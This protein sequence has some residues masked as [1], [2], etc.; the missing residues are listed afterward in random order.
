MRRLIRK[1]IVPIQTLTARNFD[2]L[3]RSL[4]KPSALEGRIEAQVKRLVRDVAE[5]GDQA[6]I[7]LTRRFDGVSL[8]PSELRVKQ[9]EVRAAYERVSRE[10]LM[11]LELAKRNVE[12]AERRW[13]AHMRRADHERDGVKI[14]SHFKPLE[15]V[16][17]Y[18]PGGKA[19]YPSSVLMNAL[20][21]KLA[22]V[23]RIVLCTPPSGGSRDVNSL[24][25]VAAALCGITEIYRVGGAQAIAAL[26]YGTDTIKP[27]EKIVGPGNQYV[28]V[29]KHLVSRHVA[30]DSPAGPSELLVIADQSVDPRLILNDLVSQAEHGEDSV[31]GLLTTSK[32]I[33]E[34]VAFL[35]GGLRQTDRERSDIITRAL[36]K[37]GFIIWSRSLNQLIRFANEFAPE[38]LEIMTKDNAAVAGRITAAGLILVGDYS[39]VAAS[40]YMLGTN[41][42]LPTG[43][44]ARTY[45]GLSVCDFMKRMTVVECS[46]DGLKRVVEPIKAL[47]LAEG[48][49]NHY[50]AVKARFKKK[51]RK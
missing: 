37:R 39:P 49:P 11:A 34:F 1:P 50:L 7:E 28:T 36:A 20:P 18:V 27:V 16:G 38:H 26:A 42:V 19:A 32:A 47:A 9:S 33:A 51:K 4:R 24:V 2:S 12:R 10:E 6:V 3:L 14:A 25:L 13:L 44:A 30:I 23:K 17:C 43:G 5:R 48:L 46:E 29:A 45:S 41:H 21:A 31:C 40:D 22:G 15:S 35:T 8:K